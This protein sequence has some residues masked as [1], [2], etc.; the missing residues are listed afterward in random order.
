VTVILRKEDFQQASFEQEKL[1]K[2][3]K[4]LTGNYDKYMQLDG[5]CR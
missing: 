2:I 1:K 4:R 3:A 5:E